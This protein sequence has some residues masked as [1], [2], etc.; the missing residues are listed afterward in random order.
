MQKRRLS[1]ALRPRPLTCVKIYGADGGRFGSA[2][3]GVERFWR[4]IFGGLAAARFHRPGSGIGLSERAQR[5]IRSAREVTGAIDL[6]SCRPRNDLLAGRKANEAYCLAEAG[7]QYAVYFPARGEVTLEVPAAGGRKLRW[8]DIDRG[9][10]QE[11]R[12]AGGRLTL[13]TPGAGQWAAVVR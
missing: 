11:P 4:N 5:M 10:W 7:K 1:I 8:Y 13:R 3:D 2:R 9:R 12:P 6:F